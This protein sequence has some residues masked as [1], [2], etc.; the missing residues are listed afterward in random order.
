MLWSYSAFTCLVSLRVHISVLLLASSSQLRRSKS[1]MDP[2]L[3]TFS[4]IDKPK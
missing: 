1:D 3:T 2:F 4:L